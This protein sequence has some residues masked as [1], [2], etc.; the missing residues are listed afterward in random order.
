MTTPDG[1]FNAVY[2]QYR[3]LDGKPFR[4][5]RAIDQPDDTHDEDVLPMYV[6][7]IDGREYEAW[8]E[9]IGR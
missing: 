5:V 1:Y 9:E 8:P 3:D 4:L 6:I 7:L 2:E